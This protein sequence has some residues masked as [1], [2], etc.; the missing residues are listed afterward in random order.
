MQTIEEE[1]LEPPLLELRIA[2][3]EL[4]DD[5]FLDLKDF[6]S[7]SGLC[8]AFGSLRVSEIIGIE[9]TSNTSD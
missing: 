6:N 3:E 4:S 9:D 7:V 5:A 1:G 8:L 2:V